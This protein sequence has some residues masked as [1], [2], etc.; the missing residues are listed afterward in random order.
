MTAA[1]VFPDGAWNEIRF[2]LH[3][4]TMQYEADDW[5][6]QVL[7]PWLTANQPILVALQRAGRAEMADI[8]LKAEDLW[9]L[10]ALSRTAELLILPHQPPSI[11]PGHPDDWL[12]ATAWPQFIAGIGGTFPQTN[13]F[14]P[15][16]HEIVAVEPSDDPDQPPS[17]TGRSWPGC[18]IGSLLLIRA[19]VTVRA[20]ARH[21]NPH[22]ATGSVLYWASRR[23]HRPASDL[24]HGWGHN[25]QWR[26][27]FRRDYHL[28]DQVAYNVDAALDPKPLHPGG[29]PHNLDHDLL[30]NR[31]R[32]LIDDT[33]EQWPWEN[34]AIEPG[35]NGQPHHP[36]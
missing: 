4:P 5:G 22:I 20:G 25:S 29:M 11:T 35:F 36:R 10:Y 7:H 15:F 26:T 14:H 34:H 13:Q 19:G 28:N 23:R 32:T 8:A 9:T 30:R 18:M 17:L 2:G 27:S 6:R 24:S 1:M 12:T 3:D 16:L 33:E 21:L 31:C